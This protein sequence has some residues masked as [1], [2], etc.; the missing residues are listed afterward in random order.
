LISAWRLMNLVSESSDE[1]FDGVR[2]EPASPACEYLK[3]LA[4]PTGKSATLQPWVHAHVTPFDVAEAKARLAEIAGDAPFCK[5]DGPGGQGRVT[6]VFAPTG[7]PQSVTISGAPFEGTAVG[8]CVV[9]LFKR[10]RVPP[11]DGDPLTVTKAF[12]IP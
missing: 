9:G 1:W 8:D 10:A 2:L 3:E 4:D 12:A 5:G 6:I 7:E 11:F